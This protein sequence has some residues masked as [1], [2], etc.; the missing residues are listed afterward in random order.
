MPVALTS[1]VL[2][3]KCILKG[4]LHLG[5]CKLKKEAYHPEEWQYWTLIL[6][7]IENLKT[8]KKTPLRHRWTVGVN[9]E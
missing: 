7:E 4:W 2:A 5:T 8:K 1:D 6:L 3:K 9:H